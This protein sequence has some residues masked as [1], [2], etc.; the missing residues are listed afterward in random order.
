MRMVHVRPSAFVM[1]IYEQIIHAEINK[2]LGTHHVSDFSRSEKS[3]TIN[4]TQCC[5]YYVVN[6]YAEINQA[7]L[8]KA[9]RIYH[10]GIKS[11]IV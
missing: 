10:F 11:L 8:H 1:N 7:A 2:T 6:M 4:R 3:T 5:V 9:K